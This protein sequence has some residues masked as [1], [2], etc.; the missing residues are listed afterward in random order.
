MHG[1]GTFGDITVAEVE[2][3][4]AVDMGQMADTLKL[5][6]SSRPQVTPD[7]AKDAIMAPSSEKGLFSF[8][9]F[10]NL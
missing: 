6:R 1:L 10:C 7:K 2:L 5:L 8:V 9:E 3:K 4:L